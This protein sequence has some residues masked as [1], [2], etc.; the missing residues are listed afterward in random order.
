VQPSLASQPAEAVRA[1]TEL[2]LADR[3]ALQSLTAEERKQF[4]QGTL[5]KPG[6]K[7]P[8]QE[9]AEPGQAAFAPVKKE[10]TRAEKA[11]GK[12]VEAGRGQSIFDVAP[13]TLLR[14]PDVPQFPLPRAAPKP[15]ERLKPAMQGG[16]ER[17]ERAAA[18]APPEAWG[19]Y[20][21]REPLATFPHFLGPER[22]AQAADAWI[23][24]L[25]GTSMLNPI[26]SN[27][28]GSSWYLG[29]VMRGEPL[30]EVIKVV[31]PTTGQTT[32]AMVGGPPAGYGGKSQ[33]HHAQRVRE[34]ME[35]AADPVA[36][37]K[38]LSYGWNLRG[39]WVPRTI[40]THDI[41]NM[42]GMPGAAETFGPEGIGA[43][44]PGEY[45]ALEQLGAHAAHR[46]GTPQAM[47]QAAT[48][49]GGG[50]YTGLKSIPTPLATEL[51]RRAQVTAMV[52][53]ITPAQAW[54]DHITGR[55]ALLGLGG[56]AVGG[57]GLSQTEERP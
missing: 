12:E 45:A 33:V 49:V 55:Q 30:P 24:A 15:T 22:G 6:F 38:P 27:I 57:A 19:W 40:D 53:G 56:A 41:R 1:A 52:R 47:Q 4:Q 13:E 36:N 9:A 16:L 20:N 5:N 37:P 35:N 32:Q 54:I 25:S 7:L 10:V 39:N 28:R 8:S 46:A 23:N 42:I 17:V 44:L 34:Y 26:S 2:K 31:D 51:N 18:A 43:L 50:P 14:Q 29:K 21:L 11:F 3:R 48:W